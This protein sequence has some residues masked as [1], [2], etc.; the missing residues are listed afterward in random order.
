MTKLQ[1]AQRRNWFKFT[2]VG[3]GRPFDTGVLTKEE[4]HRWNMIEKLRLDLINNFDKNSIKQ[5]LNVKTW[6][7]EQKKNNLMK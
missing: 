6:Q 2:I 1:L 3:M 7:K 4:M 5:G